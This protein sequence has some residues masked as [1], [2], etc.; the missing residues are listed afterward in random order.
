MDFSSFSLAG[1]FAMCCLLCAKLSLILFHKIR[2]QFNVIICAYTQ[3]I[4]T[5]PF[6]FLVLQYYF[7][8]LYYTLVVIYPEHLFDGWYVI[9]CWFTS[10]VFYISDGIFWLFRFDIKYCVNCE[11][12]L[13]YA[14][15]LKW[16]YFVVLYIYGCSVSMHSW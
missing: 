8:I 3:N 4:E 6:Y 14:F 2:C 5:H 13:L 7:T 12:W 10:P 1:G 16:F 11:G 15:L 9:T